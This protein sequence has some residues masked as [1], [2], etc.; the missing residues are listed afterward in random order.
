MGT[1]TTTTTFTDITKC[2]IIFSDIDGTLLNSRHHVSERTKQKILELEK[3]GIPFILVSA[4]SPKGVGLI[5]REI[6]NHSPIVCYSGGLILDE[7]GAPI[8]SF[9]LPLEQA[10]R[11]KQLL[12]KNCPNVCCNAYGMEQWAVDD[13]QNPW[14]KREE[15]ITLEKA[16][17]GSLEKIFGKDGSI[18]KFLLMGEP[19]DITLAE[20]V[21][22]KQDANLSIVRS[23]ANYLEVMEQSA[24]K[25]AGIRILC[26]YYGL[27]PEQA[28]A[29]GDGEND[30]DM[31]RAVRVS[32]AMANAP[33]QVKRQARFTTKSNDEEGIWEALKGL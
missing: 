24:T 14:V 18:H 11:L 20:Q 13:D 9:P 6:G 22:K 12:Q 4:R 7:K 19:D 27:S 26:R 16:L 32:F 28:I 31:L 5:Q 10:I 30:I 29:F 23:N 25:S 21:L 17:T 1:K 2:R 8:N 15:S 3:R 33:E